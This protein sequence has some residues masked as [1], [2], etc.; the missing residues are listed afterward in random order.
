M[1]VLGCLLL[2]KASEGGIEDLQCS[3]KPKN[4]TTKIVTTAFN[5]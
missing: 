2:H 4:K 3:L 1:I 5:Y